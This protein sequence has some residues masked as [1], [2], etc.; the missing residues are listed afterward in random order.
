MIDIHCHILYGVDDGAQDLTESVEMARIAYEDGMRHI[1][2]TPHFT[3]NHLNMKP[4]VE[5]K[6]I[7]LQKQLN[8]E[9]IPITIHPGNEVRLESAS[10]VYEHAK[11]DHFCY[12]GD[13]QNFILLEQPWKKYNENTIEVIKWLRSKH[14]TPIIAHPERHVFFRENPLLLKQLIDLG[15]WTQVTADSI[16]G[17]NTEEAKQFCAW[18]LEN[19][20]VSTLATDAHNTRRK[21]NLSTGF[22]IVAELAGSQRVQEIQTR[23]K[24]IISD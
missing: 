14:I 21:P 13:D 2:A 11:H 5:A 16:I 3:A 12:L 10:F 19:D 7:E 4:T 22:N 1:I 6:V 24:K 17:K 15:C 18:L 20:F 9:Q 8:K 23:M